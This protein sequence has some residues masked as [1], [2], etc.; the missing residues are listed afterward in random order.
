[1]FWI[2]LP[3][4]L[5]R[6]TAKLSSAIASRTIQPT[7]P[8]SSCSHVVPFQFSFSVKNAW[9]LDVDVNSRVVIERPATERHTPPSASP[10][11]QNENT[12]ADTSASVIW[13]KNVPLGESVRRVATFAASSRTQVKPDAA[14]LTVKSY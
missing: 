3:P 14:A 2:E 7:L 1:M 13:F 5:E 4:E 6:I 8:E 11:F 12:V 10:V 9:S